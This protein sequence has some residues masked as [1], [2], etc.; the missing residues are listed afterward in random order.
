MTIVPS[1]LREMA[2]WVIDE[3]VLRAGVGGFVTKN[4]QQVLNWL[5]HN[6][7]VLD[8]TYQQKP[9]PG[10]FDP[11]VGVTI[12]GWLWAFWS[13][14]RHVNSV[15]QWRLQS[16]TS[17]LSYRAL[18]MRRGGDIP[19]WRKNTLQDSDKMTYACNANLGAPH[20]AD[21]SQLDYSQLGAPSDTVA[22]GLGASK[23]LTLKDC[24]VAISA[25]IPVVIT[26]AQIRAALETLVDICV[27]NPL[28]SSRGGKAYYGPQVAPDLRGRQLRRADPLSGESG[29]SYTSFP[30]EGI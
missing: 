11:S 12:S 30:Y 2:S 21:C 16:M 9:A 28:K 14:N 7:S 24:G 25:E 6:P 10:N 29:N 1:E 15:Q 13:E 18:A 19:W 4:I 20:A 5:V 22:I 8:A 26:W 27:S 3:C 17:W 23:V